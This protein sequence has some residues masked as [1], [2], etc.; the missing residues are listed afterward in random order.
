MYL[1]DIFTQFFN[2]CEWELESQDR[3]PCEN[4]Y[5]SITTNKG[6]TKK[7]AAL[8]KKFLEKYKLLSKTKGFDY[9]LDL[10][11]A[12]WKYPFRELDY[13]KRLSVETDKDGNLKIIAQFP[14]NLKDKFDKKF[15]PRH[16]WNYERKVR[17]I[18]FYKIDIADLAEFALENQFDIDS[19]FVE[20]VSEVEEIWNNK[21]QIYPHA[22]I[23]QNG[24]SL[25]NASADAIDWFDKNKQSSLEENMFLAKLMGYPVV[26]ENP[27]DSFEQLVSSN[28]TMFQIETFE[29]FFS[30]YNKVKGKLAILLDRTIAPKA[31]ISEFVRSA[32][33][34]GISRDK[35]VVCFR[36]SGEHKTDFNNWIKENSLGGKVDDSDIYI[37]RHT[38]P[39]W[40]FDDEVFVK[41]VLTNSVH[42]STNAR[43]THWLGSHPCVIHLEKITPTVQKGHKVVKL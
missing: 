43:T 37:F 29:T 13:T 6:L 22:T 4:F 42:P 41:I 17:E 38:P 12:V 31:W 32:E 35:I 19:T 23:T 21:D 34:A 10:T 18:D 39:K 33:D 3:S 8:A 28:K 30:V 20:A 7:Q 5:T 16:P 26:I 1:E 9:M 24:V 27:T 36:E 11:D 14:Y 2:T 25:V 40:L 15:D